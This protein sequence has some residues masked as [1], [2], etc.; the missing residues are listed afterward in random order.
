MTIE[1]DGAPDVELPEDDDDLR[2]LVP[3]AWHLSRFHT[4]RIKQE[5]GDR[6]RIRGSDFLDAEHYSCG[7]YFDL[8]VT[9]DVPFHETCHLLDDRPFELMNFDE[10]VEL[11]LNE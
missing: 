7:P 3:S 11:A 4:A 1:S 8:L 6:R 9:D 2:L 10:F 5:V